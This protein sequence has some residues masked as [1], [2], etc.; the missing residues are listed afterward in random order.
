MEHRRIRCHRITMCLSATSFLPTALRILITFNAAFRNSVS[1]MLVNFCVCYCNIRRKH[2]APTP[3]FFAAPDDIRAVEHT[4][5]LFW[6][7]VWLMLMR[8]MNSFLS[9][10]E[11]IHRSVLSSWVFRGGL[12][13]SVLQQAFLWTLQ[14]TMKKIIV[15]CNSKLC[16]A[17]G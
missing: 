6:S 15:H 5:T 13:Q 17:N 7:I 10:N 11:M 16:S 9:V 3:L 14:T 1:F 8:W 2:F 12:L 4:L